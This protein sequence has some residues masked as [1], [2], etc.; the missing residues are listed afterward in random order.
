LQ[1]SFVSAWGALSRF[2]PERPFEAWLRR[3]AL[4]KCRDRARRDAVRRAALRL[5]GF[6]GG[7][8]SAESV[9]PLADSTVTVDHALRRLD[10]AI[11]KLSRQ[12]KEPLVLTM[13]EGLSHKEVGALLGINAKAVETRVY[14]AKRQLASILNL[15][16]LQDISG[17]T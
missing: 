1:E 10:A 16:D 5:F 12:L 11:G 2:D 14:R 9:A 15:E 6:G 3:I 17:T 7:D 13:L 8:M 4:N